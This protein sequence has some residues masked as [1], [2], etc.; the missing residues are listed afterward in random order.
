MSSYASVT[1]SH[2]PP[3]QPRPDPSLLN[4]EFPSASIVA[5]DT[6][7]V[8][9]VHPDFKDH[10][11]TEYSVNRPPP[12]DLPPTHK[13]KN[14]RLREAEAEGLYL[15]SITKHYLFR[16]GVAGG[17]VG[18]CMCCFCHLS[19][20]ADNILAV[21]IGL[22]AGATRA[23]YTQP[24]LR[25][26]R[27][28]IA[29]TA[30][31][32]LAILGVEGFAAEK[33]HQTPQGQE[34]ARL[35]KKEGTII[36]KV[37]ILAIGLSILIPFKH[38]RENVLRPGVL[39]GFLG[40]G[41]SV[42]SHCMYILTVFCSEC[43]ALGLGRLLFLHTLGQANLGQKNRIRS[44]CWSSYSLGWRRVSSLRFTDHHSTDLFVVLLLSVIVL[45][46]ID[47]IK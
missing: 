4:T 28:F 26:D 10:P 24:H 22:L 13:K 11:A 12:D 39:G 37:S 40:L 15:W 45:R 29:S 41:K 31:A 9:V 6:S 44:F 8:N 34:E 2:L 38:L 16:P 47:F 20:R 30:A 33:Y 35:A 36:Y 21:N 46:T 7:K 3:N 32:A 42:F 27:K 25:S 5:D 43:R 14:R 19:R 23:F 18:L 17:L 1:S